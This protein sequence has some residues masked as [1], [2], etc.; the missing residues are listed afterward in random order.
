MNVMTE[1][2]RLQK[3]EAEAF[4]PQWLRTVL[5]DVN[6]GILL[7]TAEEIV[8][9]NRSYA[10]L[11]GYD[12]REDLLHRHISSVVADRDASRLLEF[13]KA[14]ARAADAPLSYDFE[15]R[16]A[17][18]SSIPLHASISTS[19]IDLGMVITTMVEPVTRVTPVAIDDPGSPA[20]P[21]SR[22]EREV[23]EMILAGQRMKEIAFTLN[24]SAKTVSTH[25]QRLLKKLGL[26]NIRDLFQY[27]L[28]H[29]IIDWS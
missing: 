15:A 1:D 25:R 3:L 6:A 21:L 2:R 16:K 4:R 27:A 28:R 29:R 22:R 23:M 12:K 19:V 8:Y 24:L 18:A 20:P 7:E 10:H 13:G 17:D 14:R 11:L 5:D 26:E 9:V